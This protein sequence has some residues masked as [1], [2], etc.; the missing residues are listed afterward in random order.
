MLTA[1]ASTIRAPANAIR[2]ADFMYCHSLT[3][4]VGRTTKYLSVYNYSGVLQIV[5]AHTPTQRAIASNFRR[6]RGAYHRFAP[7]KRRF[8]RGESVIRPLSSGQILDAVALRSLP[9]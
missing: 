2:T 8:R 5:Q 3:S 6:K 7:T 9:R 4:F 1:N